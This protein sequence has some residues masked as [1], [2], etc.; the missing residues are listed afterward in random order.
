MAIADANAND[1]SS[2]GF[3][4]GKCPA[5]IMADWIGA[6]AKMMPLLGSSESKTRKLLARFAFN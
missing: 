5:D 6:T 1:A 2:K 3:L 4:K